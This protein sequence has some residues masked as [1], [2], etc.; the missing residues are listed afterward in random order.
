MS[1]FFCKQKTA[2]EMRISDWS[3]DVCSSDLRFAQRSIDEGPPLDVRQVG[4]QR[5]VDEL[6]DI[7][8]LARSERM[9]LRHDAGD[10]GLYQ[11]FGLHRRGDDRFMGDAELGFAVD[12]AVEHLGRR[13]RLQRD[14]KSTRLN[15]SQ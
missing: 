1:C 8:L 13:Q 4:D 11:H 3:S 15:S 14:R 12:D 7:D 10:A 9:V 5:I 2:Y 6:A